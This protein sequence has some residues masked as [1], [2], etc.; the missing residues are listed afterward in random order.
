MNRLFKRFIAY[1]IDMMVVTLVIQT[2]TSIPQINKQLDNYNKYYSEYSNLYNNYLNVRVDLNNLYNDNVIT[3]EEYELLI[4]DN[5]NYSNIINKYYVDGKIEDYDELVSEI[6][7]DYNDK[8]VDL[9][10]KIDKNMIIYF[11]IYLI[12]IFSY[13]VIFNVITEGQTL[14]KKLTRL[15]I[16]NNNDKDKKVLW[17][18]YLIRTLI[19]YQP[20]YYLVR[21]VGINIFSVDFYYFITNIFYNI[22]MFLE[23]LVIIMI[24]FKLDGRGIHDILANTRVILYDKNGNEVQD[25][26]DLLIAKRRNELKNKKII[27]EE[28]TK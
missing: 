1:F 18:G 28:S 25:K 27:D 13:F 12:V 20:V 16:V 17:W 14:G 3:L 7:K 15:K 11:I 8:Y 22:C 10:Y 6:D 23:V 19:L 5:S 24:G 2:L 9:Y 26:F 21:L 4:E